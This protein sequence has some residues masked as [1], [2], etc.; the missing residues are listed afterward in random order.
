MAVRHDSPSETRGGGMLLSTYPVRRMND[1][2]V[3]ADELRED[4]E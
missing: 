2:D 1:V 3:E 4:L